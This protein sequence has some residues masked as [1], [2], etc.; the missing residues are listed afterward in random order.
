MNI[1]Q[2]VHRSAISALHNNIEGRPVVEHLQVSSLITGVFNNRPPQH[3]YHF[4]WDIQLVL[5]YLKKELP[6]NSDLSDKLLTFN[7]AMLLALMS[8][9]RVRGL[10]LLDTRFM[11]TTLEFVAFSQ[12]KDLR[13]L[14]ALDK[15]LNITEEWRRV[16][17]ETQLLLI[18]IFNHITN[19]YH[20]QFQAS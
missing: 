20:L 7:I 11:V 16:N 3:K 15:Y 14:S 5:D 2:Y 18:V 9:S 1:G 6:N 12:D 10:H 13:V 19:W 4:I 17:N 8:A